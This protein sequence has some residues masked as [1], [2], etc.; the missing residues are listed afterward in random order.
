M[1]T[2][3]PSNNLR[4]LSQ[5][6]FEY[7]DFKDMTPSTPSICLSETGDLIVCRRYVNYR[8]DDGGGYVNNNNIITK[9]LITKINI[10]AFS[11]ESWRIVDQ[12][13]LEYNETLDD[14]YVGIEDVRLLSYRSHS[15][16]KFTI[17][18]NS[19]RGLSGGS[20]AVEHGEINMN[21]HKTKSAILSYDNQNKIE[22]NWVLFED[23]NQGTSE[24][25]CIYNWSPLIIGKID[26][27]N[28]FIKHKEQSTPTF[29]KWVR[30]STNGQIIG[31]EIWFIN[32]VVNYEDR[33][34]Y[35]HMITVL[36]STTLALKKYTKLFTF[37]KEK[38]EYTLGFVYLEK[39]NELMIGYSL[40]DRETKYMLVNKTKLDE[41]MIQ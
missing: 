7:T 8:I 38:V 10:P 32:H 11:Q 1:S 13:E 18:Y 24:I 14:V 34:Y 2:D 23:S 37:E 4:I 3:I 20:M 22:K 40:M 31:D 35:Y 28:H 33:R 41:M 30:G 29:F 12:F 5:N 6:M 25:K 27:S 36:D 39:S 9:N 19:N 26:E 17:L 15:T 16:N 21:N